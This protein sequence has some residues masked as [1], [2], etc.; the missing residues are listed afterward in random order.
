MSDVLGRLGVPRVI[1]AGGTKSAYG[2]TRI[3]A[4]VREVMSRADDL[5]C[6]LT[7]LNVAIG[8]HIANATGAEAGMITNGAASS[9]MLAAIACM[10]L[11]AP[12]PA[13]G[14][15]AIPRTE[16][17]VQRAHRG[18]YNFLLKAAGADVREVGSIESCDIATVE[19]A[20][21]ER[22]VGIYYLAGPRVPTTM[23]DVPSVSALARRRSLP[24]LVNAAAMLPPRTN[25]R[26]FINEG[27]DLVAMSG[28]KMIGG[29]QDT[30]LLFGRQD[31]ISRA[32]AHFSPHMSYGRAHK[33]SKEDMLGFFVAFE[34]YLALDEEAYL[35][36][37]ARRIDRLHSAITPLPHVAMSQRRDSFEY[38]V[39]TL[40]IEFD[41]GWPGAD[42]ESLVRKLLERE[43]AVFVRHTVTPPRLEINPLSLV[44]DE[45]KAVA[46]AINAV[47][48]AEASGYR[49]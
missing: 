32:R 2:G 16:F 20:I 47:L 27:A 8:V 24:L 18:Q 14:T 12:A 30:G 19:A 49:R 39:P 17:L 15:G 31:L 46:D 7:K 10:G 33:T 34:R 36:R 48:A 40:V 28:G 6:D 3:A 29:P 11:E 44:D 43:P 23:A 42:P 41:Q 21:S 37:M 35:R 22:T 45:E 26:R 5:F 25:L 1:H 38:F 13:G 4:E 9:V